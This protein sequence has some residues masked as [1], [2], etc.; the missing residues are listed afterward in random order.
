MRDGR[1]G[2]VFAGKRPHV[3]LGYFQRVHP[4]A[5]ARATSV[6]AVSFKEVNRDIRFSLLQIVC[7]CYVEQPVNIHPVR[8]LGCGTECLIYAPQLNWRDKLFGYR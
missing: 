3:G 8:Q 7:F 4:V 6:K 2:R 1:L 5:I